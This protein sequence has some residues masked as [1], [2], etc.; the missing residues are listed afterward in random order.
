MRAYERVSALLLGI[1]CTAGIA[2]GA[3]T[4]HI[5]DSAKKTTLTVAA[6][7]QLPG[8]TLAA[9]SYVFRQSGEQ[10]GWDIVQVYNSDQSSLVTTLLAY[11]NPNLVSNGQAFLVYP[12]ST[13]SQTQV[14]EAFFFDGDAVGQQLAYPKKAADA[15]SAAN[16]VRVPTTGTSDAYPSSLPLASAS[17]SDPVNQGK[18]ANA[19]APTTQSSPDAAAQTAQD[20]Q[21]ASDPQA[22]GGANAASSASAP[23]SSTAKSEPLPQTS[24]PLPLIGLIGLLAVVGIV[25]LR[26]VGRAS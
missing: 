15:I 25:V 13:D 18:D 2:L 24:S 16:H 22:A 4:G 26:R 20:P 7:T 19:A 5:E 10:S 3:T 23:S 12:Q 14:M 1:L 6:L 8:T 11:P 9:G 21:A 17:W